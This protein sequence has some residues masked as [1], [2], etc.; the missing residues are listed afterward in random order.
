MSQLRQQTL[1]PQRIPAGFHTHD[2]FAFESAVERNGFAPVQLP[3]RMLSC[4][5]VDHSNLLE[6]RMEITAYNLHDGSFRP[7]LGL[8]KVQVYSALL[9]AVVVMK[10]S[11]ARER[12]FVLRGRWA[13][14]REIPKVF[15]L[16]CRDKAFSRCRLRNI[17]QPQEGQSVERTP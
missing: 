2:G 7:S 14:S 4:F 11:A 15:A 3:F 9:G 13:R 16:P 8:R 10:S 1:H 17:C 6:T 12:C 5:C